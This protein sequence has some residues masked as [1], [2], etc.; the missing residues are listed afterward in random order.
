MGV[1]VAWAFVPSDLTVSPVLDSVELARMGR[2]RLHADR[3]RYLGGHILV[4]LLVSDLI[5][6]SPWDVTVDYTCSGCGE[7]H[8]G[9]RS[10]ELYLSL[11]HAGDIAVAAASFTARV[12]VDV[13]LDQPLSADFDE[14]ALHPDERCFIARVPAHLRQDLRVRWWTRKEAVLKATGAGLRE[15]P[16]NFSVRRS[17]D[18]LVDV[19]IHAGYTCSLAVLDGV[20]GLN[21]R[22]G[23]RSE[24][25]LRRMSINR[26]SPGSDVG[27]WAQGEEG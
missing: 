3:M 23:G 24:V 26:G 21:G 15:D 13:E 1:D 16:R 20:W 10:R 12:G 6:V 22:E 2:Y 11:S 9:P 18:G 19:S 5:G 4:R 8:G 14:M 7:P 17:V 27:R 25:R